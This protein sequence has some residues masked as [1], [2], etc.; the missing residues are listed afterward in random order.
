MAKIQK[1]KTPENYQMLVRTL[2]SVIAGRNA[3]RVN[4]FE[5]RFGGFF[6]KLNTGLS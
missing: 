4:H 6:T 1:K 5:R 2:I 3:K